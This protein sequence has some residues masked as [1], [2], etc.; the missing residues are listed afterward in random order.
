MRI[1]KLN[2]SILKVSG[3]AAQ[4]LNGLTSNGLDQAQN[5]FLT[6]H[7]R[8]IATFDQIKTGE[9]E[10]LLV[11]ASQAVEALLNHISRYAKLSKT[12]IVQTDLLTYFDLDG[13]ALLHPGDQIIPQKSGRLIITAADVKDTVSSSVF[14]LFRL[15]YQLP[16]HMIDYTDEMILN[17][18]VHD[19]VSYTKGCFLG[20]EPVSKVYNRSKPSWK[21]SVCF[22]DELDI[23]AQERLTSTAVDPQTS[24]VK[25]FAFIA[26]S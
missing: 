15:E 11:I 9:D 12:T 1:I 14:N 22:K 2:K 23:K 3:N 5:A 18:S 26:N 8:I 10:F 13:D 21:L 20:Q 7:G 17:V 19:F 25:G 16:L 4:F 24:R 6:I